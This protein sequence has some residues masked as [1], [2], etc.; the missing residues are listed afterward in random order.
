[1]ALNAC[2]GECRFQHARDFL[3]RDRPSEM[4]LFHRGAELDGRLDKS[5]SWLCENFCRAP[6]LSCLYHN[7]GVNCLLGVLPGTT[8]LRLRLVRIDEEELLA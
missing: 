4:G 5:E 8:M 7:V 1:M 3:S 2:L 6:L